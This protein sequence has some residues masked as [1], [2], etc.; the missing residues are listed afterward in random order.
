MTLRE[1]F[2]GLRPSDISFN[3]ESL[4]VKD[5]LITSTHPR[6]SFISALAEFEN[7]ENNSF[8][9]TTNGS[10]IQLDTVIGD[11]VKIGCNC[12]IGGSGFGYEPDEENNLI[13]MPHLGSVI[14]QDNVTIHNNVNI[15][16]AVIGTTIIGCGTKID[17]LS[18]IAHGAIIGKNCA[19]IGAGIGGGTIIGDCCYIGFRAV[20]KQKIR[21]GHNAKIGMG[22]IILKDVPDNYV[23][24]IKGIWKG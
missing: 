21:I 18:H 4:I 10:W 3:F 8:E 24:W 13:R 14:I 15:D 9:Q 11:N 23:D 5:V 19:I 22:A 6:M 17:S 20:I 16:R 1:Q 2:P 7:E 12:T